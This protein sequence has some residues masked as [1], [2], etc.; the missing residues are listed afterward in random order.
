MKNIL[1]LFLLILSSFSGWSQA[2][3]SG[4]NPK[5]YLELLELG[6]ISYIKKDT[7]SAAVLIYRSPEMGL[8]N[9]FDI[10]LRSDNT[11]II[12]I[13]GTVQHIS[14]WLENFYSAMTPATG[15]IQVND[16]TVFKY[17]L[18]EDS[19]VIINVYN[20]LGERIKQ[21]VNESKPA[22]YYTER[23]EGINENSQRVA[24][25]IYLI[26]MQA[27]SFSM[28]RKITLIR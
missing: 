13:R 4:F 22:G 2:T 20:L 8:K 1:F 24:S 6:H 3:S 19:K 7:A 14:S 15:S 18:A 10:W 23:W 17:Q 28:T 5:E 27:G 12:C 11:A 21:L 16:S 25:G 9:Q 26:Y